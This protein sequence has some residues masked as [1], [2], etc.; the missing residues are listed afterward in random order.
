MDINAA[1]A[2]AAAPQ[3]VGTYGSIALRFQAVSAAALYAAMMIHN[4]GHAIAFHIDATGESQDIQIGSREGIWW[5]PN[6]SASDYLILTNQ[7]KSSLSLNLSLSDASGKQATQQ[8]LLGPAKTSRF[9]TRKLILA[10]GLTGSYGGIKISTTAHAGSLDSLHFLFDE[11]PGFSATLKMFDYD[12]NATLAERDYARTGI[13]TLR[14]PMLALSSPDPALALPPGTALQPQLFI[15]NTTGKTLTASLRFNWRNATNT[16]AAPGPS[17]TLNPYATR[18]IDVAAL[19]AGGTLPKDANWA[20]VTLTTNGLPDEL[21]AVAASYDQTLQY[22]A[23]TP[24]SDQL[25]F[26]W[27]GGMWQYDPYHDS[28]ITAGNGGAKPTQSAFTIFYNQGTQRYDLEQTLQ[29][30]EQMWIDVGK[31]I[32]EHVQDKNG[33]VL[34]ADLTSGSYEFR[35]LTNTGI[36]S[37]F[38]GKVIYD[39]TYGHVAYGCAEC[40]GFGETVPWYNPIGVPIYTAVA[41]GVNALNSCTNIFEDESSSFYN[42]WSSANTAIATVDKYGTHTGVAQGSTTSKTQGSLLSPNLKV[43][44]LLARYPTGG[45]KVQVPTSISLSLGSKVSYNGGPVTLDGNTLLSVC[46]GYSQLVTYTVLD[47]TGAAILNSSLTAS[48]NVTV[49]SSNPSGGKTTTATKPVPLNSAGQ[50]RDV[51]A[52]CFNAPP[53]PQPGEFVKSKQALTINAATRTYNNLRINCLDQESSDVTIT[54]VTS[55]PSATCQ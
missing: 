54:D 34:P 27:E 30:D 16:G 24:F 19:Q 15:R 31:L 43:C 17:L 5:L 37:L 1:I 44:P 46:Y 21:I 11:T 12:P 14:A 52:F 38:E 41:D 51:L 28:I 29:P 45:V 39:K 2:A 9:S 8:V 23:Q 49:V 32:R 53:P 25:S 4:M 33:N 35:D 3:L 13:W 26:R 55:T 47:Q 48:E 6:D 22:G 10:S 7:G 40:C 18:R 42:N 20:S 50:F 36:G